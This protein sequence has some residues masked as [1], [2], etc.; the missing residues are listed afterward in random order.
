MLR[1]VI[2]AYQVYIQLRD[3]GETYRQEYGTLNGNCG[4]QEYVGCRVS[5]TFGRQGMTERI[6][7]VVPLFKPQVTQQVQYSFHTILPNPE[8]RPFWDYYGGY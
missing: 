6:L 2:G 4:L 7:V 8:V 5:C 3:N 1:R